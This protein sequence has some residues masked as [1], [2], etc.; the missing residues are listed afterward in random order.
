M[1]TSL[2]TP[3]AT[4]SRP[5]VAGK[6][7]AR[8]ATLDYTMD[9]AK[10]FRGGLAACQMDMI[11]MTPNQERKPYQIAER[12]AIIDI[13]GVLCND[14]CW[15]DETGYD[16]IQYEVGMASTDPDVDSILMCIN[17]PGGE[18]DM[19]FE[20]A[21]AI[22]AAGK[23]KPVWA[24]ACPMAYSAAYLMAAQA[25]TIYL[26]GITGGVGSIGVYAL[27]MDLSGMLEKMGVK[28][29]FISAGDGKT[30]GNPYE[31]LSKSARDKWTLEIQRLYGEFVSQVAAG[32]N[33]AESAIIKL[34]AN[35]FEGGKAALGSGLADRVGSVE[36]AWLDLATKVAAAKSGI[37]AQAG[38]KM[39]GE[40]MAEQTQAAA[41][42][43][44]ETPPPVD[45]TKLTADATAAGFGQA[46]QIADMCAL[47]GKP[48][49]AADFIRERKSVADVSAAL[50]KERA[51]ASDKPGQTRGQVHPNDGMG[52]KPAKTAAELMRA[53]G[54]REGWAK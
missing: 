2:A 1:V 18:T 30:D 13:C 27:H 40:K 44:V 34:G 11:G 16:D 31:P 14:P 12:V 23:L 51:D 8:P 5:R 28:P 48:E 6:R 38:G 20:T 36:Q 22:R 37:S 15:W 43:A 7:A 45:I 24:V 21:L 9:L 35:L 52:E 41:G 50:L 32:R 49:R 29:T 19:A 47:A 25:E 3:T 54:E 4:L 17:S 53:R 10:R 42:A 26:P 39:K 33:M 46:G